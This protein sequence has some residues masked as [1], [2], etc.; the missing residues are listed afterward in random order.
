MMFWNMSELL[1]SFWFIIMYV[2][3]FSHPTFFVCEM[4]FA[5]PEIILFCVYFIIYP[6]K[7]NE[8]FVTLLQSSCFLLPANK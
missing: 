8:D 6:M 5:S 2:V 4:D 7:Y 1:V 3:N